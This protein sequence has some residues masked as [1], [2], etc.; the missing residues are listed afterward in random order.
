MPQD[1]N[2]MPLPRGICVEC[3]H[4]GEVFEHL[5]GVRL[6]YCKHHQ[7]GAFLE[8][9]ADGRWL[10]NMRTPMTEADFITSIQ[11]HSERWSALNPGGSGSLQ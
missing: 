2:S 4:D 11:R 5:S 1:N 3:Q 8:T 9:A 6:M 10:W 7:T